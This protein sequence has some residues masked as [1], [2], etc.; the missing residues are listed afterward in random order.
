MLLRALEIIYFIY[1]ASH[2]P[3][4]LMVDLQALLPKHLYP[5]EVSLHFVLHTLLYLSLTEPYNVNILSLAVFYVIITREI[6][7]IICVTASKR[8]ALVC[9]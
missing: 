6:N 8:I 2:I 3:I 4:T 9:C 1:F 5:P 7:S